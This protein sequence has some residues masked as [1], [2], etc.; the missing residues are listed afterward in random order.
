M[1]KGTLIK[2][3]KGYFKLF[4]KDKE[5][6]VFG[7]LTKHRDGSSSM[8]FDTTVTFSSLPE[9]KGYVDQYLVK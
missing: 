8:N 6:L 9:H 4:C 1:K 2:M 5:Y 7:K 3:K